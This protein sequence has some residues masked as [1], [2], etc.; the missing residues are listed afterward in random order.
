[1]P[2][3]PSHLAGPF[4]SLVLLL[5]AAAPARAADTVVVGNQIVQGKQ[6]VGVLCADGEVF[7]GPSLT[8]KSSDTPGIRFVQTADLYLA[9]TWDVAG[10]EGTF[11]V[12]D[13]SGNTTPFR[14]EPGAPDRSLNVSSSGDISTA[15]MLS[16]FVHPSNV[17]VT[18]PADGGA[19]LAALRG[20][21][22][23]RYTLNADSDST[24]HVG[25]AGAAF[26]AAFAT[27]SDAELASADTA[28]VALAAIK[29]LDARVSTLALTPGAAGATGADG[30]PGS[31]VAADARIA[32]LTKSNRKL[33]KG[34]AS[35]KKQV[36]ALA[37]R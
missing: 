8:A 2:L 6:C 17:T 18:G 32:A 37:R 22:L 15:A 20:L 14:V 29:A 4:A 30:A 25:P 7:G 1:V 5:A 27:G 10:N 26:R 35:L 16:Q 36:R 19:I 3:R 12:K 23:S 24:P 9:Q 21:T 28:G 33:T 13:V 11:F 34:L 31:L